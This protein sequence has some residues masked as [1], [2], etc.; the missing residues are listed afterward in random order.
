MPGS[1]AVLHAQLKIGNSVVMLGSEMP[2]NVLSPKSRGGTS[3]FLHRYTAD[4]DAD[5]RHARDGCD[6]DPHSELRT[7]DARP[8]PAADGKAISAVFAWSG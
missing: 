2:P 4:A 1:G 8:V 3:V 7:A 6:I 5:P